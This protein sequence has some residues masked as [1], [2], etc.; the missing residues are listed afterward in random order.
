MYGCSGCGVESGNSG[1]L[2]SGVSDGDASGDSL[3]EGLGLQPQGGLASISL[4]VKPG[5]SD[6]AVAPLLEPPVEDDEEPEEEP[7]EDCA[8]KSTHWPKIG[9]A[10]QLAAMT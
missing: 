4:T 10:Y 8:F 2:G 6:V 1:S 7:E 3:G 9:S 5:S